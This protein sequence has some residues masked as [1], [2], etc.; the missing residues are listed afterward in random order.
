MTKPQKPIIA[1]CLIPFA[2]TPRNEQFEA[3][4]E[5]SGNNKRS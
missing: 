3:N 5:L 1:I 2:F 4:L